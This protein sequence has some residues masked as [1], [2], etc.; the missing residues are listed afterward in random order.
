MEDQEFSVV[1]YEKDYVEF[2]EITQFEMISLK[3]INLNCGDE[4]ANILLL[5]NG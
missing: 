2:F 4:K 1:T 3:Y 5:L